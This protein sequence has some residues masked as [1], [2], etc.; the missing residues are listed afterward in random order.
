M[1]D[2]VASPEAELAMDPFIFVPNVASRIR[3][4]GGPDVRPDDGYVFHTSYVRCASGIASFRIKI[5]NLQATTGTLVIRINA[6]ATSP[7]AHARLLKTQ[8]VVMTDL[9]YA[10]G[11]HLIEFK[12]KK[13]MLYA[14]LGHVH[15][16]TDATAT[17][18][19]VYLSGRDDGSE[20]VESL[21]E[22]RRT[23][24]G[25]AA[26]R[27][28]ARLISMEPATLADPVSQMCTSHQFDEP[29]YDRW[30]SEM[31]TTKT[32]HRKQWEFVYVLQALERYGMLS[33]GASGVGFGVGIE[34]LPAVFVSHGCRIVATDLDP[35]DARVEGWS[36]TDQHVKAV[37]DLRR[38]DIVP[39]DQ[40]DASVSYRAVDMNAI[41]PDLTGFDFCWSSC[42]FEHLGSIANGLK[43]VRESLR[44][45]KPGGLAVHTTELNL[46]SN[47]DTVDRESTVL[48]R[49][50]DMEQLALDLV[51]RGHEVAQLKYDQGSAPLDDHVDLP[52]Y[53]HENH[54]KLALGRYVTTS[55]GL[56]VRKG[57]D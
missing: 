2:V 29:A 41:P 25:K 40:F 21:I 49:R 23:V 43:F 9:V 52:P 36:A 44:C 48:F 3:G 19:T 26:A 42:A 54:L 32:R 6:V 12:A 13:D 57:A 38:P 20:M 1:S 5:D 35:S 53:G 4:L 28:V 10:G 27:G 15:T 56:I 8:S 31:R 24:F 46:S 7:G 51:S 30:V 22:A 18:M 16:P 34:P 45:L 11:E 14:V 55:F 50:R 33:P 39:D 37:A 47:R 17:A